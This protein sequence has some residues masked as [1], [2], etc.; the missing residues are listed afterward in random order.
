ME[1]QYHPA[2]IALNLL[3]MEENRLEEE[4]VEM[5]E[6]MEAMME[7]ATTMEM[8]ATGETVVMVVMVAVYL[9]DYLRFL[10]LVEW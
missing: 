10:E 4:M 7:M 9:M 6:T 1:A 5:G 3:K 2:M 8:V